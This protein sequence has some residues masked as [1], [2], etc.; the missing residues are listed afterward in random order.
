M[1]KST[2]P[3]LYSDDHRARLDDTQGKGIAKS[4]PNSIVHLEPVQLAADM[5]V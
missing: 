5:N 4:K 3:S 1:S 2:P